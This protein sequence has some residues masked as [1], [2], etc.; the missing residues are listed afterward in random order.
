MRQFCKFCLVGGV[1]FFSDF[2]IFS[3]VSLICSVFFAK[4]IGFFC[5][6]QITFVLHKIFTFSASK[7]SYWIYIFGQI[8]GFVFN[9]IVFSLC[10]LYLDNINISFFVAAG[11]TLMFNFYYAKYYAFKNLKKDFYK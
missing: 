6:L 9:F 2:A 8:K 1:G 10:C 4:V 3:L 5:A 7:S 11:M